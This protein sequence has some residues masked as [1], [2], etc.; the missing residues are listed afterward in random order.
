MLTF[1]PHRLKNILYYEKAELDL[2]HQGLTVIYGQN[3]NAGEGNSNGVGKSL[4]ARTIPKV[5]CIG[6]PTADTGN[7][8]SPMFEAGSEIRTQF[9]D[10]FATY[11]VTQAQKSKS[12]AVKTTLE[13]NGDDRKVRTKPLVEDQIRAIFPLTEEEFYTTVYI[14]SRRMSEFQLG[15]DSKR[16]AFF[17]QL[18]QLHRMD[19]IRE[20]LNRMLGSAK[21][22]KIRHD[23]LSQQLAEVK[24]ATEGKN[25][26]DLDLL[27]TDLEEQDKAL[28]AQ[29]VEG[30]RLEAAWRI[31]NWEDLA[32]VLKACRMQM[33]GPVSQLRGLETH[34]ERCRDAQADAVEDIRAIRQWEHYDERMEGWN[35]AMEKFKDFDPAEFH[36][37]GGKDLPALEAE[38][39]QMQRQWRSLGKVSKPESTKEFTE[40]DLKAANETLATCRATLNQLK[41]DIEELEKLLNHVHEDDAETACKMCGS[42]V[43]A[44][45]VR[46]YLEDRLN[47][48]TDAYNKA[49]RD[50][51]Q[52]KRDVSVIRDFLDWAEW[53]QKTDALVVQIEALVDRIEPLQ[54]LRS[55]YE[56]WKAVAD[57]K[58]TEPDCR[59][60][61]GNRS[62]LEKLRDKLGALQTKIAYLIQARDS[63]ELVCGRWGLDPDNSEVDTY[64]TSYRALRE[65][66]SELQTRIR[67]VDLDRSLLN[68]NLQKIAELEEQLGRINL[69][70]ATILSEMIYCYSN[71][72]LKNLVIAR[73]VERIEDNLNRWQHL[74]YREPF[75]FRINVTENAFQFL[76][77]G[78]GREWD[79]REMSGAESRQF[80]FL[81]PLACLPL[82]PASRR[83]NFMILDEP[84]VNMSE[85][86]KDMFVN[87][88][89]P[90]LRQLIPHIIVI[91]PLQTEFANAQKFQAK[92]VG[93]RT[94]LERI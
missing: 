7:R 34:L 80:S 49:G 66:A 89:I 47:E 40:A 11:T 84:E 41:P 4:I 59:R 36:S 51:Q 20:R 19:E 73:L 43:G 45:R 1:G 17:T 87:E 44:D 69:E 14:D 72:G 9:S 21:E 90:Q 82:I 61:E 93:D 13:V 77:S 10:E 63:L 26:P 85:V 62:D 24:A 81:F 67:E 71:K 35:R 6:L 54:Q 30:A 15:S 86:A 52:A 18:F 5:L 31:I 33:D 37:K 38:L 60:L 65:T 68:K 16:F 23:T 57:E 92:L 64:F 42:S 76:V 3:V 46:L 91:T 32:Y 75:R 2:S 56:E 8:K 53:K 58:P 29:M 39:Q 55:K 79:I 22:D 50:G 48:L 83:V 27:L 74:L 94:T 88:F 28:Q 25:L 70:D 78:R 12:A